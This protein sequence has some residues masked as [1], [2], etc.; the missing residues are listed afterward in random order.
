MTRES[1]FHAL[2][3]RY[4]FNANDMEKAWPIADLLDAISAVGVGVL[5]QQ[6][7]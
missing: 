1:T 4:G 6:L 3:L 7:H 2:A 5:G